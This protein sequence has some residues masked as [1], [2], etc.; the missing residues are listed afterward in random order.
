MDTPRI[1]RRTTARA[2]VPS[3]VRRSSGRTR[4]F[5]PPDSGVVV[6]PFPRTPLGT[7]TGKKSGG[8]YWK[9]GH[10]SPK[11]YQ[12]L[13]DQGRGGDSEIYS[14][15]ESG[16]FKFWLVW[17]SL[18]VLSGGCVV[19]AWVYFPENRVV[20]RSQEYVMTGLLVMVGLLMST[21]V[22][23]LVWNSCRG[24]KRRHVYRY[25]DAY[26]TDDDDAYENQEAV[27]EGS[28]D[29]GLLAPPP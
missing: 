7:R 14:R 26:S 8:P 10:S 24:T 2:E 22:L 9:V 28:P 12:G 5:S 17:I 19:S 3:E 1:V 29:T 4:L 18:L 11:S 15:C 21:I 13:E 25:E 23:K 6:S 27:Y 16:W 20:R